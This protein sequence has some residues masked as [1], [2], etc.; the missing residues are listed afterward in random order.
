MYEKPKKH[1]IE[2]I[3]QRKKN[4]RKPPEENESYLNKP[5]CYECQEESGDDNDINQHQVRDHCH[6]TSNTEVWH[7]VP[8]N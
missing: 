2:I 1:T 3:N 5:N 6:Y 8:P 4:K 7:I